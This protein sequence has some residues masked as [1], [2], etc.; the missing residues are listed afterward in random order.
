MNAALRGEGEDVAAELTVWRDMARHL[1][2]A[3]EKMEPLTSALF[4]GLDKK[5]PEVWVSI[6]ICV[7]KGPASVWRV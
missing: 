6:W 1:A 5:V 2:R 4:R 7:W 3:L